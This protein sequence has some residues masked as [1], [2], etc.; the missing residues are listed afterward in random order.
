MQKM[1]N[2]KNSSVFSENV[3]QSHVMQ[4]HEYNILIIY[5]CVGVK[6]EVITMK[7]KE[8]PHNGMKRHNFFLNELLH[9]P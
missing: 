8:F 6:P 5:V 3:A 1:I 9:F 2:T 4:P 7:S